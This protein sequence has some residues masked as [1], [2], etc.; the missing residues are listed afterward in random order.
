MEDMKDYFALLDMAVRMQPMPAAYLGTMS[1]I[2]C[3]DCGKTGQTKYHFVGQKCPHCGSYNT[4]EMG[5]VHMSPR[6]S[7][8]TAE[9]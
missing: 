4:R 8:T 7:P 3:Q 2:Y 1:N 9:S 6:S 5:R